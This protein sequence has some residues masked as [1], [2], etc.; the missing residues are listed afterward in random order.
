MGGG[1]DGFCEDA[2]A[3][4]EFFGE[5]GDGFDDPI[6]AVGVVI[7]VFSG[8]V[9]A[10]DEDG[11]IAHADAAEDIGVHG[12]SDHDSFGG[13]DAE[14]VL[15]HAHHDAA[16]LADGEGGAAGGAFDHGDDGSAAGSGAGIGGAGGIG[17]GGDEARA[18]FDESN[19]AF[20]HFEGEGA[21]FADDD[22][23]RIVIDDCVAVFVECGGESVFA[24]DEGGTAGFLLGEEAG[25]GHGAGED[26]VLIGVE[27]EAAEF[28]CDIAAGALGVVC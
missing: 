23:V 27:A 5:V 14:F 11:L 20:D 7:E 13:A 16:G 18:F 21:A 17:V 26:V 6:G 4:E 2:A 25:G 3:V 15:C 19:T 24:D 9:S 10:E 1:L 8:G 12:I 28:E 22:V